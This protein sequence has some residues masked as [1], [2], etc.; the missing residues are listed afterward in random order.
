MKKSGNGLTYIRIPYKVLFRKIFGIRRKIYTSFRFLKDL[1]GPTYNQSWECGFQALH[2]FFPNNMVSRLHPLAVEI[3]GVAANFCN[4]RFDLLGSGWVQVKHGMN[5]RGLEGYHYNMG[6]PA[7]NDCEGKWLKGRINGSNTAISRN[8]WVLIDPEYHPIDWQLDF[9]SGYRWHEHT[10]YKFIIFG[11][12]LGAD[13][14]VPWE[15]A[16]MQHLPMLAWAFLLAQESAVEFG[17]PSIYYN[18]FR[19]QVLDFIANNPPR[20]GVNWYYAMD[21]SIRAAN[22][23][24]AYDIFKSHGTE[25]D[26][27]FK[28]VFIQSIYEHGKHIVTNLEWSPNHRANHYL[29]NIAGLVFVAAYLPESPE[30]D[31]WLELAVHELIKEVGLQFNEDGTNFE[32]STGYHCFVAEMV[33]YATALI[34]GLPERRLEELTRRHVIA[35]DSEIRM[36]QV[37]LYPL[38]GGGRRTPFP[39][40]YFERLEKM[41]EFVIHITKPSGELSQ[42]GD[43]DSGRFFKLQPN[44]RRMKVPDMRS[45][46]RNLENYDDPTDNEGYYH[47]NPLDHRHLV[48]AI[49]GL[50]NREDFTAFTGVE[51]FETDLIEHL[52]GNLQVVS[53]LKPGQGTAAERYGRSKDEGR[54]QSDT[55]W[56]DMPNHV[57]RVFR[58]SG[59][60]LLTGLKTFAYTDFGLYIYRSKRLYLAVR[61]GAVGQ[62]GHGGHSHND[63]LG[64]E[65]NIDG[66]DITADP[67]SYIYTPLPDQRN[68]YRSIAS[69]F[70]PGQENREPAGLN[71]GMFTLEN[72]A[73]G[74]CLRFDKHEFIGRHR[75]INLRIRLFNDRVELQSGGGTGKLRWH[76]DAH[77]GFS[78]G[79]GWQRRNT[80]YSILKG[81]CE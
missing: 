9:K 2:T 43:N 60:G 20:F 16:R 58:V 13:I 69:H 6:R 14:K 28:R 46:F 55:E 47:E 33:T 42:I 35:T 4:H 22:W 77:P 75:D 25:Y 65:L 68:L 29:A 79:Y 34:L 48:A 19:N 51:W 78:D 44:Y 1:M 59:E 40:W 24:V 61:C 5:C 62:N 45:I 18:E 76:G 27:R 80:A 31:S 41:A 54:P 15:L 57:Q 72:A 74:E 23:L 30:T 12:R 17:P 64:V 11:H 73:P 70:A 53:Y 26:E 50:F 52:S 21:V 10:W 36:D 7:A 67:G 49:N 66:E 32:A 81:N 63:Q 37:I 3:A 8:I 38:P 56:Q 71:G 39:G